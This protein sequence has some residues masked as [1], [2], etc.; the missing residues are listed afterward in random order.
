[1]TR[2]GKHQQG[3]SAGGPGVEPLDVSERNGV[4]DLTF[5]HL[6][7]DDP[8]IKRFGFALAVG[9]L[10]DALLVRMTLVPAMMSLL[11]ESVWWL[12]RWLD[13]L[14]PRLDIEGHEQ[15]SGVPGEPAPAAGEPAPQD[16]SP[17][18]Q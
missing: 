8:M 1:M 11:G 12:P 3:A 18:G 13:R 4:V 6:R 7:S 2:F 16:R 5:S 9:V 10:I 15:G 14:L 17:V